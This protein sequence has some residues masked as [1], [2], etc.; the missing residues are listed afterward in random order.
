MFQDQLDALKLEQYTITPENMSKL[1]ERL[2]YYFMW[3]KTEM[4]NNGA[5]AAAV[6][7]VTTN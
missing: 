3:V 7:G 4:A 1:K 5:V 6:A 2:Q